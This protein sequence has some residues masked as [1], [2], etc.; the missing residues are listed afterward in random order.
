MG[1]LSGH[2]SYTL[3]EDRIVEEHIH[4]IIK[5]ITEVL[6]TEIK[7][8]AVVLSGSLGRGEASA[9]Q[10]DG[11]LNL[12]SDFEIGCVASNS[13]RIASIPQSF[14]KIMENTYWNG[15]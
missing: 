9:Y 5:R 3:S 1:F 2:E 8:A 11:Q 13:G 10:K 6:I 15:S 7:P 14:V 12:I 4:N